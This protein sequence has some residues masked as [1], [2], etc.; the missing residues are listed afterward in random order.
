MIVQL[1]FDFLAGFVTGRE[2]AEPP[3]PRTVRRPP[4]RPTPGP[5]PEPVAATTDDLVARL[6]RCGVR[7][8]IATHRNRRVMVSK[9]PE[10]GLRVHEG[11]RHAPDEVVEA[12]ARWARP[13]ARARD[14]KA[15]AKIF[16][17][18]QVHGDRMPPIRRRPEPPQPGDAERLA[19]I[20]E[21]HA[22]LNA[23]WFDGR[24]EPIE[25]VLSSRMRRKLGHYAPRSSGA[26]QIAL[27]RR[28]LARDGWVPFA[29]T[30]LHEMVHQWQDE[31]GLPVDHGPTFR[32]QA[33]QGGIE[34]RAVATVVRG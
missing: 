12:I 11:Y 21:L 32:A 24:L 23:E 25:I 9:S 30:L 22:A 3:P 5:V 10:A 27:S 14:R 7:G 34:P 28:H 16:L 17:A 29:E 6:R 26:P 18:F 13:F 2:V 15:A 1:A 19:R 8:S 4:A 33:R 20:R 31:N